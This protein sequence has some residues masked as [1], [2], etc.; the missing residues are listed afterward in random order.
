MINGITLRPSLLPVAGM[1]FLCVASCSSGTIKKEGS[2]VGLATSNDALYQN[3]LQIKNT[4][5]DNTSITIPFGVANA[6]EGELYVK[7]PENLVYCLSIGS[8]E[9]LGQSSRSGMPLLMHE[10]LVISWAPD[11]T[12]VNRFHLFALKRQGSDLSEVW[13]REVVLPAR[14]NVQSDDPEEFSLVAYIENE[15][16]AVQWEARA[17]YRGGAAPPRE[18]SEAAYLDESQVLFLDMDSGQV[19][20]TASANAERSTALAGQ[21]PELPETRDIIAYRRGPNWDT[22]PWSVGPKTV[23]LVQGMDSPGVFLAI[24]DSSLV[25]NEREV[26][27]TNDVSAG[28]TVT[29]DGMY[30]LVQEARQGRATWTVYDSQTGEQFVQ[31]PYDEGSEAASIA[32]NDV[33]YL[34]AEHNMSSIR[35]MLKKRDLFSAGRSWTFFLQEVKI[36]RPPPP[37]Q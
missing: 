2:T 15:V 8:G 28:L 34:V 18:V 12:Q 32:Q 14:A 37:R 5:Q 27:L 9:L 3:G 17:Q 20:R 30:V 11:T 13:E 22:L 26:R 31:L 16:L 36:T 23:Q 33:L 35:Y 10:D 29:P 4:M 6:V 7:G 1:L 19:I 25:E 24:K 21:I